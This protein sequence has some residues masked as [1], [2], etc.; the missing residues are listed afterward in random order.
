MHTLNVLTVE[1]NFLIVQKIISG[2]FYYTIEYN[3]EIA[4]EML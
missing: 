2:T 1:I 3:N 4:T